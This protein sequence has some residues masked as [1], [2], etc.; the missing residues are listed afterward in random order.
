MI[1]SENGR[2][3]TMGSAD[4]ITRD[5]AMVMHTFA[6]KNVEVYKQNGSD[7]N[8]AIKAEAEDSGR[9]IEDVIYDTS[10]EMMLDEL[11][12]IKKLASANGV[13]EE[14]DIVRFRR[15]AAEL[16]EKNKDQPGFI[17]FDQDMEIDLSGKNIM[18]KLIA[19]KAKNPKK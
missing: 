6:A 4:T 9:S 14:K 13:M 17:S 10:I 16:K 5:I 12:R 19:S 3:E 7:D 15:F 18:Q 1:H 11:A 2:V 8:T